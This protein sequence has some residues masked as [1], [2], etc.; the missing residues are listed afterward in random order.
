MKIATCLQHVAFEGPGV[1][2]Q[3]LEIRGYSV[4]ST[5]V[6]SEELP[7]DPGD[8]LLIMGGP[9]SVNDPEPWIAEERQ[10]LQEAIA[11]DIPI[12]GICFG[13]QLL[14]TA[15]GGSVAPG[16]CVEIGMVPV[17]LTDE[18]QADPVFNQGPSTFQV[19]QWHGEGISLPPEIP[20]LVASANFPVQAFRVRERCYGLLF[21]LEMEEAGIQALCRECPEDVLKS[22]VPPETIH[23]QAIRH[24]P[25]SHQLADRLIGHLVQ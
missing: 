20:S 1:F 6:P 2:R 19:F 25:L 9:M 8:F 15:V 5:L 23:A 4:R 10:F 11:K 14:A 16:L 21:H 17:T 3:A 13:S 22:G 24:L 18:G 12:L 7:Q